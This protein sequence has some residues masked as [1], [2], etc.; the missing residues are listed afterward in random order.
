M[1][2]KLL[3]I[4]ALCIFAICSAFAFIACNGNSGNQDNHEDKTHTVHTFNER[5][6]GNK[7]LKS[8]ATC[9]ESAV[10]Y[11]SCSCGETGES[12]FEYGKP[13]GHREVVDEAVK[14]TCTETVLSYGKNCSV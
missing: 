4:L 1:K 10:F 7:Y 12:T 14:P 11:Y 2:R 9:T 13:N 6:T 5:S 3:L 8:A